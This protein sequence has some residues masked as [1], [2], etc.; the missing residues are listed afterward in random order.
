MEIGRKLLFYFN[1]KSAPVI[2][3]ID[4]RANQYKPISDDYL[5]AV[6]QTLTPSIR[7]DIIKKAEFFI[8]RNAS[9][10]ESRSIDEKNFTLRDAVQIV[11]KAV[12]DGMFWTEIP[13]G[14]GRIVL[15]I[16]NNGF[17]IEPG[18]YYITK[19]GE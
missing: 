3:H 7:E 5:M 17:G 11:M 10:M 6:F 16:G 12:L 13:E 19:I 18:R 14:E 8:S 15:R 9:R 2:Y 1:L 4:M